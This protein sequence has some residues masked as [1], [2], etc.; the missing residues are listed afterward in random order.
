[1][2]KSTKN[3]AMVAGVAAAGVAAMAAAGIVAGR[4]ARADGAY[5]VRPGNESWDVAMAGVDTALASHPN[6][7]DAVAAAR[8]LAREHAPSELVIHRSDGTVQARHRYQVGD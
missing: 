3:K 7:R 5:H 4:R 1:M 8:R 6:K 2:K